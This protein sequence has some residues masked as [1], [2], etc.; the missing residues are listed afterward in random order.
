M[1]TGQS[2]ERETRYVLGMAQSEID[3]LGRQHEIWREETG[4]TWED[5][6]IGVGQTILDLGSGPGFTSVDL[7]ERVGPSG[8]IVAV[9]ASVEAT[10]VLRH[11]VESEGLE[12]LEVITADVNDLDY[13][14]IDPDVINVRWLFSFIADPDTLVRRLAEGMRPGSRVA[15]IDY[16]NY[17][18][19]HIEPEGPHFDAIFRQVYRSYSDGGGSLDVGGRLPQIFARHG[20]TPISIRSVGGATR[21]GTPYWEWITEFQHLYLPSLVEKGYLDATVV[22]EHLAWWKEAG[23]RDGTILGLPPMVAIV[24][25]RR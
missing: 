12:R 9:D 5:A 6:G 25:E 10:D 8:R 20:I 21:P 11:R 13:G 7:L 4:R 2:P 17:R 23:E 19:I 1:E 16:W 22:E 3:R 18:A 15:V 14:T 24:G